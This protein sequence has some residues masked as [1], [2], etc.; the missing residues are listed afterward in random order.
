ML[1][2]HYSILYIRFS[3]AEFNLA[4][5]ILKNYFFYALRVITHILKGD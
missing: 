5:N 1:K 3:F 4:D 2:W